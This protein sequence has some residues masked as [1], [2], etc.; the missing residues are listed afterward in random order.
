MANIN[1]VNVNGTVYNIEDAAVRSSVAASYSASSAYAVGDYCLHDGQLYKCN[2]AI[3]VGGETWNANHWTAADIMSAVEDIAAN[4]TVIYTGSTNVEIGTY[5]G[6]VTLNDSK[7]AADVIASIDNG[8]S[9]LIR[10]TDIESDDYEFVYAG[11]EYA[12]HYTFIHMGYNSNVLYR[13][14]VDYNGIITKPWMRI[15]T[16]DDVAVSSTN[17]IA[18]FTSTGD[19]IGV[20][21]KFG[22]STTTFLRNDGTWQTP[23]TVTVDS[24]LSTTSENPVQNK[25][26]NTALGGKEAKGK[27]TVSNTEYTVTR[28]ALVITDSLGTTTTYYV[29][30]ITS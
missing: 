26:I 25:V 24:A 10:V 21:P 13:L 23:P 8:A 7:T 22:S 27:I 18:K 12:N 28:K 30:D 6:T 11:N 2:T 3:A 1:K 29:A 5:Q 15:V 17:A 19:A 16:R 20:G 14:E 9:V 4:A